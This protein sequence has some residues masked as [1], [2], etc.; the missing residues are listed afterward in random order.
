LSVFLLL[1]AAQTSKPRFK[2]AGTEA[3]K[4]VHWESINR[5]VQMKEQQQSDTVRHLLP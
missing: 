2:A 5:V 4:S 1:T 3:H